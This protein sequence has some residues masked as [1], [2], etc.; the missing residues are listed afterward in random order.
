MVGY[1]RMASDPGAISV[2]ALEKMI[3]MGMIGQARHRATAAGMSAEAIDAIIASS[4]SFVSSS[5]PS[6]TTATTNNQTFHH[7]AA[8]MD[9]LIVAPRFRGPGLGKALARVG[10]A[11]VVRVGCDWV[12]GMASTRT[13]LPFYKSLGAVTRRAG[14]G[15]CRRDVPRLKVGSN[16]RDLASR[17]FKIAI[18]SE[19]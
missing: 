8:Y 2:R 1:Q 7:K 5:S 18:L 19:M 10:T 12:V 16:V 4:D 3:G 15:I 17:H 9:I 13:F 11:H 6:A 14:T